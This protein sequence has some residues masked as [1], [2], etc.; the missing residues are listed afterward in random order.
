[1]IDGFLKEHTAKVF[2]VGKLAE[3]G[4]GGATHG[5]TEINGIAEIDSQRHSVNNEEH[6][7]T[8][9]LINS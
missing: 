6:C 9:L 7:T 1:M 4:S 2:F 5:E 8:Q 3:N